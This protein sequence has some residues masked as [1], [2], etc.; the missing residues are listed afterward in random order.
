M[1]KIYTLLIAS[2]V[3]L[4]VTASAAGD[5]SP[6]R[7][8]SD[9]KT[10]KSKDTPAWPLELNAVTSQKHVKGL[11]KADGSPSIEGWWSFYLG[12]YYFEDSAGGYIPMGY[13]AAFDEED[14][15]V[16]WFTPVSESDNDD[17]DSRLYRPFRAT[18]DAE[19][20]TLTIGVR[21]TGNEFGFY[22][23]QMPF[24]YDAVINDLV[25]LDSFDV[26]FNAEEG[27]LEFPQDHGIDW[28]GYD[29]MVPIMENYKGSICC[30][31]LGAA[32][33]FNPQASL[34]GEWEFIGN[35]T[36]V[37][38]WLVPAMNLNNE[39]NSYMVEF[40]QKVD[41]P[42]VYRLVNP[43]KSGPVAGY[44]GY[45]GDGYIVFDI[46]DPEHV[47]F[48][49]ADAGFENWAIIG[50]IYNFYCYNALG[51]MAELY[52]DYTVEELVTQ[53]DYIP[54]T[55]YTDNK[56]ILGSMTQNGATVYDANFGFQ[57]N[58]FGGNFFQGIKMTGS[59]TFPLWFDA[60]VGAIA[61]DE[62]ANVE[63]YN[64]N[65]IRISNPQPGQ[66]VIK[67]AGSTVTKEIIR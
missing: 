4:S 12:D 55:R 47:I 18:Y 19:T 57:L 65:G 27:T 54:N 53:F 23:F 1:K 34:E 28:A 15:S 10:E 45:E 35:V 20:A 21:Y 61:V 39:E 48:R 38:P 63:Y 13:D 25:Y 30:Y 67:R 17:A 24:R 66:L 22:V 36:F 7:K 50:G 42:T 31:D 51:Y 52:P 2:A 60:A 46:A 49:A 41:E 64:L 6:L 29:S 26:T 14:S 58:P 11:R 8:R 37:D 44:N 5:N 56:V 32:W 16:I 59:I 3:T 43:Y 40:E 9:V 62:N 33:K